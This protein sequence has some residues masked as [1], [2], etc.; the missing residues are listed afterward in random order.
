[1]NTNRR[2]WLQQIGLVTTGL[3]IAQFKT[4][5]SPTTSPLTFAQPDD[6]Q[7]RLNSN[8]NPYGASPLAIAGMTKSINNI[9]RYNWTNTGD[10]ITAIAS[11]NNVSD[12]NI[13]IGAGS[14]EIIDLVVQSL[15]FQKGCFIVANPTYSSWI[16]TAEKLGLKKISIPLT[17][18]KQYDLASMLTAIDAETKLIYVCNPNNPTG[19]IC[20]SEV[21]ISFIK[22]A[23]KKVTVMIDE[24]YIDYTDQSSV[25]NLVI[26]NKNLIVVKTFSK[27]YGLAGARIGYAIAHPD[28]VRQVSQLNSW[29]NG[30]I[31]IIARTAA[32]ESLKDKNFVAECYSKNE[33][34][35]KYTI[36]QLTQLNIKCISSHTNFIY[37]SLSKYKKDYFDLL[38]RNDIQGTKIYE[39]DGKWTRITVGTMDE[40]KKFVTAL[41]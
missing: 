41:K 2:K 9:N 7:I 13:L 37:F 24:A 31:S 35:K 1:M 39:E 25:C 38:K 28:T 6:N 32:I 27:I 36:E 40:M 8:E 14:T 3:G 11:I 18:N 20:K 15:A 29:A 12:E 22:E 19:T 17:T 4:F 23:T 21:L 16:N 10:L 26:D 34:V 33:A 5:A 30:G